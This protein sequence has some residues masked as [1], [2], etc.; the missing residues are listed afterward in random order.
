MNNT[1]KHKIHEI[2]SYL[3]KNLSNER[4]EHSLRVAQYAQYLAKVYDKTKK[5]AALAYLAG[6]SHDIT[7]E[8]SDEKQILI[9]K[10]MGRQLSKVEKQRINLLH[11]STA[12]FVLR[13]KFHIHKKEILDALTFHTFGSPKLRTIG[14][15]VFVADKIEPGREESEQL[16]ALVGQISFNKLTLK[17]LQFGIERTEKKA[18]LVSPLSRKMEKRLQRKVKLRVK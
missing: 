15:L 9:M 18:L 7:K 12:A 4:Y 10:K 1:Y 5:T 2:D 6:L 3:K 16:R 17:A 11:G 13:K 8:L 14:K